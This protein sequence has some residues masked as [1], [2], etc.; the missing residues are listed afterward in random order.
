MSCIPWYGILNVLDSRMQLLNVLAEAAT[1][2]DEVSVVGRSPWHI[3]VHQRG[4]KV[5]A[6]RNWRRN[7]DEKRKPKSIIRN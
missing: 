1:H 6:R 3:V 5:Q 4:S 2:G 7:D